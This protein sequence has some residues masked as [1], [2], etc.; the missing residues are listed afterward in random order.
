MFH[1]PAGRISSV[2]GPAREV[3]GLIPEQGSVFTDFVAAEHASRVVQHFADVFWKQS[4][5]AFAEPMVVQV[6]PGHGTSAYLVLYTSS[7]ADASGRPMELRTLIRDITDLK[8]KETELDQIV[9]ELIQYRDRLDEFGDLVSHH[10]RAP[11][12]NLQAL[13]SLL[14]ADE[15]DEEDKLLRQA[16][17]ETI[18]GL[19]RTLHE[20]AQAVRIRLSAVPPSETVHLADVMLGLKARYA[21]Q[22]RERNATIEVHVNRLPTVSYP[23]SYI[24]VAL[25]QLLSN[26]LQF[27]QDDR[28]LLFSVTSDVVHGKAMITVKDNGK[29]LDLERYGE[30]VFRYGSTFH[31]EHSGRGTGLFMVRTVVE[32]LGGTCSVES[33]PGTGTVFTIV[34]GAGAE[35]MIHNQIPLAHI[36]SRPEVEL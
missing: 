2:H 23:I 17:K 20:V 9:H 19:D 27:A 34:L 4:Q 35:R 25:G 21:N 11:I 3:L 30:Q 16:L 31:R 12:A 36:A 33:V 1:D 8:E 7:I 6:K 10:L 29:G 26:A 14:P 24:E 28:P 13:A 18:D 5:S 32:S 15:S 22:I